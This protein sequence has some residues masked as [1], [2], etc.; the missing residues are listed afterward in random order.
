MSS[1]VHEFNR[2][3]A[4]NCSRSHNEVIIRVTIKL[5]LNYSMAVSGGFVNKGLTASSENFSFFSFF[6]EKKQSE[7]WRAER[8]KIEQRLRGGNKTDKARGFD[9]ET[10]ME[11]KL[12]QEEK[13]TRK[14][15]SFTTQRS[16]YSG[17]QRQGSWLHNWKNANR[18]TVHQSRCWPSRK[19]GFSFR[20]WNTRKNICHTTRL[21]NFYT[22][23]L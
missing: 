16:G 12:N 15:K 23:Y 14:V 18:A 1:R 21:V 17:Q 11:S 6:N 19:F 4:G 2:D 7:S 20:K 3:R 10:K 5:S 13:K 8:G 22:L 9:R